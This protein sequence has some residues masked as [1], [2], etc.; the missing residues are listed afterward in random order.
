[1]FV[2]PD[3]NLEGLKLDILK[4]L[5]KPEVESGYEN[6]AEFTSPPPEIPSAS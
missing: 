4:D 2:I 3:A 1:M 5:M 6:L